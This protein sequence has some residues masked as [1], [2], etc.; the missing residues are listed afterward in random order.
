MYHRLLIPIINASA[1]EDDNLW[2]VIQRCL[3]ISDKLNAG[4]SAVLT[5][6]QQLYCKV[7]ELQWANSEACQTL[8]VRLGSLP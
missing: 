2:T 8:V 4:Q 6:V 3:L 1:H 5:L 7:K